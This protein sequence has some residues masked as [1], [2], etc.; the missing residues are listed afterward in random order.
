MKILSIVLMFSYVIL[1]SPCYL[2]NVCWWNMNGLPMVLYPLSFISLVFWYLY[3]VVTYFIDNLDEYDELFY[4]RTII[5]II[6]YITLLWFLIFNKGTINSLSNDFFS[7]FIS[8]LGLIKIFI[9]LIFLLPLIIIQK[10]VYS[11]KYSIR[12]VY[13]IF[14]ILTVIIPILFFILEFNFNIKIL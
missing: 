5:Y 13:F 9:I 8:W 14:F 10:N 4:K 7:I 11:K 3:Y 12:K 6:I 2:S 1:L